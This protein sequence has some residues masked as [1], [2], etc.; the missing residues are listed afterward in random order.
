MVSLWT[1]WYSVM[2]PNKIGKRVTLRNVQ[3]TYL[4]V[5]AKKDKSS[6]IFSQMPHQSDY[7]TIWDS[8]DSEGELLN[9]KKAD[10]IFTKIVKNWRRTPFHIHSPKDNPE[11]FVPFDSE[12]FKK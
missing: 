10:G 9:A 3:Q 7:V 6:E 11:F 5:L 4:M 8:A 1:Q 2:D 12:M